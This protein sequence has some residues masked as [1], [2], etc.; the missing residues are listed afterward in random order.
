MDRSC[1]SSGMLQ[2]RQ[3]F[4]RFGPNVSHLI[5]PY[6]FA[7]LS[8][9]LSPQPAIW[10][11]TSSVL[12]TCP[13]CVELI[14]PKGGA[15]F[16][17]SV[18]SAGI[19]CRSQVGFVS[20]ALC[21]RALVV[22]CS[23]THE[24]VCL[25]VCVCATTD[26]LL[27][28]CLTSV[29]L[30]QF[31]HFAFFVNKPPNLTRHTFTPYP[32]AAINLDWICSPLSPTARDAVDPNV[33]SVAC[34]VTSS[35]PYSARAT[36]L[37]VHGSIDAEHS[38]VGDK[39]QLWHTWKAFPIQIYH[40]AG[41]GVLLQGPHVAPL[42]NSH[43]LLC[44]GWSFRYTCCLYTKREWKP[45]ITFAHFASMLLLSAVVLL[46]FTTSILCWRWIWYW[47]KTIDDIIIG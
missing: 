47:E 12:W 22:F 33:N 3:C 44:V 6:T 15:A 37:L 45:Q 19:S 30:D 2:Q 31:L 35:Y 1:L 7:L 23:K 32:P 24:C 40:P 28:F 21:K 13:A 14:T 5:F 11:S 18:R 36:P 8:L 46:L 27:L 41:L 39:S 16:T 4:V 10:M 29:N 38:P 42:L 20:P 26:V 25:C 9:S 43:D 34:L 17:W